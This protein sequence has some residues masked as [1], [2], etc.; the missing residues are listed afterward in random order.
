MV[1]TVS[2]LTS[3]TEW[4]EAIYRSDLIHPHGEFCW[5]SYWYIG[6]FFSI[7]LDEASGGDLAGARPLEASSR[8]ISGFIREDYCF[9]FTA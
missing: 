1:F 9:T 4:P 5:W 3:F 2:I 6:S 7:D 8:S